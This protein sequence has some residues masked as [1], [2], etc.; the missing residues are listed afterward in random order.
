MN[1]FSLFK[2]MDN[3][4]TIFSDSQGEPLFY[5]A[6]DNSSI[7]LIDGNPLGY[8]IK[9][10][11]YSYRGTHLGFFQN[12]WIIDKDGYY[13][14]SSSNAKSG[15]PRRQGWVVPTLLSR[16]VPSVKQVTTTP[17]TILVLS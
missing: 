17:R 16:R 7:Y 11:F 2:I 12:G 15:P 8:I 1:L 6:E 14:A 3:K 5:L 4:V 9:D 13:F 10:T